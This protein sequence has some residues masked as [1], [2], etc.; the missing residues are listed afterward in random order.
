MECLGH[1]NGIVSRIACNLKNQHGLWSE[2]ASVT[3]HILFRGKYAFKTPGNAIS[4]KTLTFPNFLGV[5][6]PDPLRISSLW[7]WQTCSAQV[8]KLPTTHYKPS[9]LELFDSPE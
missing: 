1:F 2:E 4:E 6:P 8:P 7:P 5:M 3:E 9:I